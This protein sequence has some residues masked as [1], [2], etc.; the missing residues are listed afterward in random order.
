V[1]KEC[2]P[3]LGLTVVVWEYRTS[4]E[5]GD[6]IMVVLPQSE[7]EGSTL[8]CSPPRR[9]PRQAVA[10]TKTQRS[11]ATADDVSQIGGLP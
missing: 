2:Q 4:Q 3:E 10:D 6:S 8:G 5:E 1:S 11:S 7:K 9:V